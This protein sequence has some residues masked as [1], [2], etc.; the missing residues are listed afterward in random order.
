MDARPIL[1]MIARVLNEVGLEAILIGNAAAALQAAPVTT[2][3]FDFLF[4]K[5]P[6]NLQKL[7]AAAKQLNAVILRPYYPA[8]DLF[9][10]VRDESG[11]QIDFMATIHG[12]TS[13]SSLRAKSGTMD[14]GGYPLLVAD[15]EE[16]VRSKRAAGRPQDKAVLAIL[17]KT[18]DET[19]R[20]T[21]TKAR[22]PESGK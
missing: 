9:R 21:K 10:M 6:R 2:I 13:F 16:V 7:K 5:T 12:I 19:A 18:L 8:S 1:N 20:H 17:E 22:R 4:R 3:D 11:L 15:L 14:F